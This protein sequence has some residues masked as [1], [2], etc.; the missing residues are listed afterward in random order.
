MNDAS[1]IITVMQFISMLGNLYWSIML[2][3]VKGNHE[4]VDYWKQENEKK[5]NQLKQQAVLIRKMQVK[6]R[7]CRCENHLHN[8]I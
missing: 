7:A 6:V 1:I 3:K 4:L 2:G 5:E 8:D